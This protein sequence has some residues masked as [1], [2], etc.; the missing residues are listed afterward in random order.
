MMQK[1]FKKIVPKGVS[2][3]K[4]E[5]FYGYLANWTIIDLTRGNDGWFVIQPNDDLVPAY[6]RIKIDNVRHLLA[7]GSQ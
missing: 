7:L 2:G 4:G 5:L 3:A 1:L 6:R